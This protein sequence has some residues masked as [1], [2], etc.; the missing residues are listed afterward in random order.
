MNPRWLILDRDGV[1]NRDSD[2]YIKS[3]EEWVAIPGSLQAIARLHRGGWRIAVATN[4][5]GLGRGLFDL[6]TLEAIHGKMIRAVEAAGGRIDAI[7]Y[8]PHR[9]DEHCR[10]RKP[11]PG[12]PLGLSDRYGFSLGNTFFVGDSRRDLQAAW[13]AGAHA[14]LVRTGNGAMTEQQM[15]DDWPPT[16]VFDDLSKVADYLLKRE[17]P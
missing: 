13:A 7:A 17:H 16:P 2:D 4:Q 8:C 9:P 15:G 11:Q 3:P 6:E 5:S 1:I 10:C 12:L 14:L